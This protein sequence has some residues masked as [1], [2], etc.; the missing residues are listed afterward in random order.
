M[1]APKRRTRI[2]TVTAQKGR[3]HLAKCERCPWQLAKRDG[4]DA[5]SLLRSHY[6]IAH[7]HT[8]DIYLED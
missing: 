6:R 5:A 7:E 8:T 3:G 1:T 4:K 2:G